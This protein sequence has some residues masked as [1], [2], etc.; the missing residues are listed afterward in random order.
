MNHCFL[1]KH[2]FLILS[3]AVLDL[4]FSRYS[5]WDSSLVV[6]H[7][8]LI[9]IGSLVPQHRLSAHGLCRR[10]AWAQDL[11]LEDSRART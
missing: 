7:G 9:A 3:L 6:V 8:L 10:R 5:E 2:F 1:L 4:L 11:Q